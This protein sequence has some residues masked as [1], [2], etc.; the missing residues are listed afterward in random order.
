VALGKA[1]LGLPCPARSICPIK[2]P[3][4]NSADM[5]EV[6]N[7]AAALL[8]L[9]HRLQ[10]TDIHA[11]EDYIGLGYGEVT[12]GGREAMDLLATTEGVL[13]DPVYTAKAMAALI[14]D[15]RR[16]R[17][18]PGSTVVFIHTGG[19]PAVFAYH[20]ELVRH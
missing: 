6:A 8:G 9:P 18:E 16:G 10:G 7:G 3:W 5:A 4:D 15:V 2:W 17:L 20:H 11:N 1:V 13:L 14:D 12:P 19:L